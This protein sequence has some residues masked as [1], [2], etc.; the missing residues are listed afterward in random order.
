MLDNQILQILHSIEVFQTPL[1]RR[2]SL[3]KL[4]VQ[5]VVDIVLLMMTF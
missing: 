4:L 3:D 2:P 1:V 5:E